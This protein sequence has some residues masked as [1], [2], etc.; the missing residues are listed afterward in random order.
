M[1][2]LAPNCPWGAR[3]V[4]SDAWLCWL[5]RQSILRRCFFTIFDPRS[6]TLKSV[7]DCHLS[8][9]NLTVK[10]GTGQHQD[11]TSV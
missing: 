2:N 5:C 11:N 10:K 7:F 9:G 8:D 6:L 1:K 3:W 4:K